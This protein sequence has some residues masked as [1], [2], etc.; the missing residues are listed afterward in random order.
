[1]EMERLAPTAGIL[2]CLVLL[3]VAFVPAVVVED[4]TL[5]AYYAAGPTGLAAVGFLATIAVIV[6]L[7]GRQERTAPDTVA[8]VTIVLGVA[9]AGLAVLWAI[10]IDRTLLFSFQAQ[11]SWIQWHRLAVPAVSLGVLGA[12]AAY[13][14]AVL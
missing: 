2:A 7:S 13:S 6:F 10:S 11:Y 1:M 8:G 14:R 4:T 12:A 5:P 3:V 9:I